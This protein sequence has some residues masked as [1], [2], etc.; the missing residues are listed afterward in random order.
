[1]GLLRHLQV[2]LQSP[3]YGIQ[4]LKILDADLSTGNG[5]MMQ[6]TMVLTC[7]PLV[8]PPVILLILSKFYV[9]QE[10]RTL[11][12]QTLKSQ[13]LQCKNSKAKTLKPSL[14]EQKTEHSVF[15]GK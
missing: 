1:M 5:E 15:P 6:H 14:N 10:I 11:H 9:L 12:P 7:G 8:C 2:V 13:E 3:A 4:A